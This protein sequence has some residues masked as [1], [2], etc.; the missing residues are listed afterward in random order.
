M[1]HE[2]RTPLNSLLILSDQLSQEHREQP[3]RRQVEFA[4]T[5]HS[6]GNDLLDADQ[7]HPRSV[8]DRIRHGHRRRRRSA[9]P[10]PARLRRPHVPARGREQEA[11]VR[12]RRRRRACPRSMHTDAKRL[13]QILKNLLSNAF[14]FTEKGRVALE[15]EPVDGGLEPGQRIAEPGQVGD[16]VLGHATPASASR[17]R[18]S[19]SSSRRSSR[20]TARTSRKYGG[21][22][23]G[24]AISREIAR[25]L[26]GEIQ[27]SSTPGAGQHVHALPA[28]DVR[29]P[30]S[31][32]PPA[33]AARRRP[34]PARA[35]ASR[36]CA[37]HAPRCRR[38][39]PEPPAA[40]REF[41]DDD[42]ATSSPATASC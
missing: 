14:K 19:R 7:R 41:A 27:L 23:L 34:T 35:A 36:R 38:A 6:S 16:R 30:P 1:S 2:L 15:V 21:T 11:G 31:R 18:S 8:Q 3:D 39:A 5:I 4:K 28:A 22:G 9:V 29:R 42:A 37:P 10:R 40:R 26:G 32:R 24:L 20:P 13:Q 17:R 25:L 12:G 33:R